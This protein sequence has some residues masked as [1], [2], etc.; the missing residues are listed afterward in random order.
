MNVSTRLIE[1]AASRTNRSPEQLKALVNQTD[2]LSEGLSEASFSGLMVDRS[3]LCRLEAADPVGCLL[4]RN[5]RREEALERFYRN[6]PD[7]VR[8]EG[9]QLIHHIEGQTNCGQTTH[10]VLHA[11]A[12]NGLVELDYVRGAERCQVF[13]DTTPGQ[14]GEQWLIFR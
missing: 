8:A 7:Q 14:P 2:F 12:E 9:N 10:E 3:E 6:H 13:I 4:G 1:F 11:P 5:P